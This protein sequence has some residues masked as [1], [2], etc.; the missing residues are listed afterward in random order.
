MTELIT[1]TEPKPMTG[2]ITAREPK[3][4]TGLTTIFPLEINSHCY[5]MIIDDP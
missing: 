2:L 3:P 1:V 4:T 5:Y